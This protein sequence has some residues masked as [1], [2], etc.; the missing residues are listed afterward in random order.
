MPQPPQLLTS[1]AFVAVSQPFAAI[2]SQSP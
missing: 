1:A 2:P